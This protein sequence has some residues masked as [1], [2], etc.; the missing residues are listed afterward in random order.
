M[1]LSFFFFLIKSCLWPPC[2]FCHILL[3][4]HCL[5]SLMRCILH[6]TLKQTLGMVAGWVDALLPRTA[7]HSHTTW[8]R[9]T[10]FFSKLLSISKLCKQRATLA[11][12]LPC[13]W[14]IYKLKNTDFLFCSCGAP[15]PPTRL[16]TP[17][18]CLCPP[19]NQPFDILPHIANK[20]RTIKAVSKNIFTQMGKQKSTLKQTNKQKKKIHKPKNK[21]TKRKQT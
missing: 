20:A 7:T 1:F 4:S 18:K 12:L 9:N 2:N 6:T 5:E 16:W 10:L 8:Q 14:T 13:I 15:P 17:P 3:I 19:C 21:Q 11:L